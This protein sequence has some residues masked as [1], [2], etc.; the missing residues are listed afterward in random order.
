M[1]VCALIRVRDGADF[2]AMSSLLREVED[3]NRWLNKRCVGCISCSLYL[4]LFCIC[5]AYSILALQWFSFSITRYLRGSSNTQ[6]R[7]PKNYASLNGIS[8]CDTK[9]MSTCTSTTTTSATIVKG[10][11]DLRGETTVTGY[12]NSTGNAEMAV[13]AYT[14][15]GAEEGPP[16][17]VVLPDLTTV[18]Q[19]GPGDGNSTDAANATTPVQAAVQP[20]TYTPQDSAFPAYPT[21]T[22][23][24][25]GDA[26]PTVILDFGKGLK[27][28]KD[29]KP[30]KPIKRFNW[31]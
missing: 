6:R 5:I 14:E 22:G 8:D 13:E 26:D 2:V 28:I 17:D 20:F 12:G 9:G 24:S 4:S 15:W 21:F 11:P 19:S 23:P 18:A 16:P 29:I 10:E 7:L 31:N 3:M 27:P 1:Q 30:I 25:R